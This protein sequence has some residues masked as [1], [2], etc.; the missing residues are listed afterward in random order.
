MPGLGL[1]RLHCAGASLPRERFPATAIVGV[2][3]NGDFEAMKLALR[4]GCDFCMPVGAP[5]SAIMGRIVKLCGSEVEPPYRVL[6]VKTP[7]PPAP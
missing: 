1:H 4:V 6:V 3:L 2:R 5:Q 7:R